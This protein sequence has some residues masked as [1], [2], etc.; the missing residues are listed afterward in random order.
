MNNKNKIISV[1]D[2]GSSKISCMQSSTE[3]N[4]ISKVIGLGIIATKGIKAGIVTDFNQATDSIALAIKDCEKQSNESVS[5][6]AVSISSHKCFTKIIKSKVLIKD[7][8][9]AVVDLDCCKTKAL[10]DDYFLDK[11]VIHISPKEY[12]IDEANG[13]TNPIAMYGTELEVEFLVT[14]IGLNQFKNYIECIT[15]CNVD[16]SRV[17]FSGYAAGYAVLNENELKLGSVIVDMGARTT[18]IG[19]FSNKNFIYSNVIAF[20]GDNITEAIA[21]KLSITFDEAE[22]LKVMHASVLETSKEEET[23]LEIPSINFENE[24]N[25]IQVSKRDLF[26]IVKPYYEEILKWV[27]DSIKKS[28]YAHLIGKVLVFTGGASQIDGLSIFVNNLYKYNSRIGTAKNLRF[29]FHHI[30]DASQSVSAGLIQN[31][32]NLYSNKNK[33]FHKERKKKL[34]GEISLSFIKQWVGEKFF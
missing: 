2:I 18:S 34:E 29:N 23:L 22:K 19:M 26:D 4:G 30:L 33:N 21:R 13:I 20:G 7:E 25:Y 8:R 16:V 3:A 5:D 11:K 14:Y 15:S 12:I 31:E 28:E 27:N 9:V 1:I 17:V 10:G 24:E 32:L 6:L